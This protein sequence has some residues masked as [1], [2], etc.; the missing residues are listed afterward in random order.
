MTALKITSRILLKIMCLCVC[1]CKPGIGGR[2]CNRCAA[3]YY[4]FPDCLPC[5]CNRSGVTPD[6]CHPDTGR[7]LCKVRPCHQKL[8][9]THV[10]LFGLSSALTLYHCR[11]VC[12]EMLL[13]SSVIPAGK[14]PSFL[15]PSTLTAAPAASASERLTGVRAPVNAGG[16]CVG[17]SCPCMSVNAFG[18]FMPAKLSV[19]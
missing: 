11:H 19:W 17:F 15:T 9:L 4:R 7:C 1:S 8:P 5:N 3:G 10:W 6:V 2:Q 18:N 16:R 12:R 14:V 13:E